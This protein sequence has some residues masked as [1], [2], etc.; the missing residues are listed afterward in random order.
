MPNPS[1]LLHPVAAWR[2]FLDRV[3]ARADA[4]A[5]AAGLTVEILAGGVRRYRDPRLDG[6]AAYRD[7][8]RAA[9]TG[10]PDVTIPMG[11]DRAAG[12]T[13]AVDEGGQVAPLPRRDLGD[14]VWSPVTVHTGSV[15][16]ARAGWSR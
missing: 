5:A 12:C 4:E 2:A 7:R 1:S 9:V 6:L 14:V 3:D 10:S 8:L 11:Y 15:R 13:V 16:L